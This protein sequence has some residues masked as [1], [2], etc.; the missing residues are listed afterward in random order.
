[1]KYILIFIYRLLNIIFFILL[2]IAGCIY[3]CLLPIWL[4]FGYLFNGDDYFN[5][6]PIEHCNNI[7][8]IIRYPL[9]KFKEFINNMDNI[10]FN[11]NKIFNNKFWK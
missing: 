6:D 7:F 3:F 11:F 2:L 5:E 8:E 9:N 10:E 4:I 1:M